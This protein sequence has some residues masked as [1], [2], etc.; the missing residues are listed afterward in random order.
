MRV[1]K[2]LPYPH[3]LGRH[4][5]QLVVLDVAIACA[6]LVRRPVRLLPKAPYGEVVE[7]LLDRDKPRIL[8]LRLSDEHPVER[9][10]VRDRQTAG[11]RRVLDRNRK[12]GRC[13]S[14]PS[15]CL[16][17][18]SMT[19]AALT[20]ISLAASAIASLAFGDSFGLPSS[21]HNNACV[22]SRSLNRPPRPP[23]RP[24]AAARRSGR[25]SKPA[26]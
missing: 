5:D 2:P 14:L 23:A 3:H 24:P 10:A 4:L 20:R 15:R 13:G 25:R 6:R 1:Q 16:V 11:L 26:P 19:E 9:I 17:V 8:D 12:W 22:S 7:K 21:A 18:I